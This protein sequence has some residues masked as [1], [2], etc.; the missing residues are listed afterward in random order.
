M[1]YFSDFYII[2]GKIP[3]LNRLVDPQFLFS[4]KVTNYF[5]FQEGIRAIRRLSLFFTCLVG[6]NATTL[7]C[8]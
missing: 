8:F 1:R 4:C 2:Y 7:T 5:R 6:I 3:R